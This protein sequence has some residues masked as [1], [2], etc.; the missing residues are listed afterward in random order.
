MSRLPTYDSR[1]TVSRLSPRPPALA[2]K[3]IAVPIVVKRLRHLIDSD[4]V[5]LG[6]FVPAELHLGP[7]QEIRGADGLRIGIVPVGNRPELRFRLG[8]VPPLIRA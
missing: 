5:R 7:R 3:E 6:L 8:K 2:Q 1:L 4:E